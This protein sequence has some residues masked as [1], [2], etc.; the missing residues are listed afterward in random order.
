[1]E[2]SVARAL[3]SLL[4]LPPLDFA[5]LCP[6][7]VVWG[8]EERLWLLI[9]LLRCHEFCCKNINEQGCERAYGHGWVAK[10]CRRAAPRAPH[11]LAGIYHQQETKPAT[12]PRLNKRRARPA[13][14][15]ASSEKT[16]SASCSTDRKDHQ[17]RKRAELILCSS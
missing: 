3:R 10:G 13:G 17:D 4:P 5:F 1:M 6:P 9:L 16:S 11:T 2:L 12:Q 8:R 14:L 7:V 15:A